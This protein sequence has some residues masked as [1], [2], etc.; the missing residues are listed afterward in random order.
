MH[1]LVPIKLAAF[2]A[3]GVLIPGS[4]FVCHELA[5]PALVGIYM[6]AS[7]ARRRSAQRG[8]FLTGARRWTRRSR[9]F[10]MRAAWPERLSAPLS[11]GFPDLRSIPC[12]PRRWCRA[13][14][15]RCRNCGATGCG[16]SGRFF[17]ARVLLKERSTP[18]RPRR[19]LVDRPVRPEGCALA[20]CS[21]SYSVGI[22]F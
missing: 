4:G 17:Q 6:L 22:A 2:S 9:R 10:P 1:G 18:S 5:L 19:S 7:P 13:R 12:R 20:L 11:A 16:F 15:P 8:S 14:A 3:C 21:G